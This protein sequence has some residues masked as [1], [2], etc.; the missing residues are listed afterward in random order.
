[1]RSKEVDQ[2]TYVIKCNKKAAIKK[3]N[4]ILLANVKS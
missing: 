1:M 3:L 2:T 4:V